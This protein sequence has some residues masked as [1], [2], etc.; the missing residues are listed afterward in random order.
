MAGGISLLQ[1]T[2]Y[3]NVSILGRRLEK[4]LFSEIGWRKFFAV[5]S[6]LETFLSTQKSLEK[7]SYPVKLATEFSL[8]CERE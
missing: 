3:R 4:F 8:F 5:R 6:M 2:Y 1:G 7:C